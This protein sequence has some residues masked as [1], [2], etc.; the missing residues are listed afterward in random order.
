MPWLIPRMDVLFWGQHDFQMSFSIR[1]TSRNAWNRHLRSFIVDTGSYQTTWS[2]SLTN[3]KWHSVAWQNTMTTLTDQIFY[4]SVTFLTLPI[5]TF[6]W[7]MRGFYRTFAKGEAC[8]KGTLTPLD[9]RSR[10]IWDLHMFF[11]L[12]PIFFLNLSLFFRTMLFEHPSV[13]SRFCCN[14]IIIQVEYCGTL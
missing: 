13:L 10:P 11:L 5:S 12:R 9:I 1:D 14:T 6:Y 4:Q 8:R 2:S 3:A 7:L